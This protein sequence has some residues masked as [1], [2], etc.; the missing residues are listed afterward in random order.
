[1]DLKYP[2]G[3]YQKP[4]LINLENVNKWGKDLGEF[5]TKL[6]LIIQNFSEE[7]LLTKTLPGNWTVATIIHHLADSHSNSLTRMKLALTE[8][9][10]TIKPYDET[11]WGKLNDSLD[12]DIEPSLKILEGVH[13]KMEILSI[14]LK[15][16]DLNR[17]YFHP[18]SGSKGS[19]GGL[20]P[21]YVWHGNHHLEH[22]KLLKEK[23]NW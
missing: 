21:M 20:F 1:M 14:N 15:E 11:A 9:N 4:D 5:P 7:M 8:D 23:Q 12:S 19:L 6:K 18:E 16:E 3:K 2:I 22:I 13:K 10:P 17:T